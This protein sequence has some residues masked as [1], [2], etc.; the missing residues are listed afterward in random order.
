MDF[1][2]GT[3]HHSPLTSPRMVKLIAFL[4][5]RGASG[6]TTLEICQACCSTRA[7]SDVSEARANGVRFV[8]KFEGT[9]ENGR[10]VTRYFL[11]ECLPTELALA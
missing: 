6:A 10:R 7:S 11:A 3:F 4:H 1:D 2:M 8:E 9:N 5:E